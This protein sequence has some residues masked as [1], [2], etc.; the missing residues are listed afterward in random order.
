MTLW[1]G[2]LC[3]LKLSASWL[4]NR[5]SSGSDDF[6][7][8]IL[9]RHAA[10]PRITCSGIYRNT[11]SALYGAASFSSWRR[12]LIV[13]TRHRQ[14]C[15]GKDA[16]PK[17]R[18]SW[19]TYKLTRVC[20]HTSKGVTD[21]H[22]GCRPPGGASRLK[23]LNRP[24]RRIQIPGRFLSHWRSLYFKSNHYFYHIIPRID[25]CHLNSP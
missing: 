12:V 13:L 15:H 23:T 14:N 7:P 1:V 22:D 8:I 4:M 3:Q 17:I 24:L 20:D 6:L 16:K 2:N 25:L 9:H 5:Q 10:H 11:Y 19:V 21:L 18:M